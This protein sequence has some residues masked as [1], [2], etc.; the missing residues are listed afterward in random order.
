MYKERD[1]LLTANEKET[2]LILIRNYEQN[3]KY[4]DARKDSPDY[5]AFLIAREELEKFFDTYGFEMRF[6]SRDEIVDYDLNVAFGMFVNDGNINKGEIQISESD[7]NLLEANIMSINRIL[8]D[9]KQ[10]T[11]WTDRE[12]ETVIAEAKDMAQKLQTLLQRLE[13]F[14]STIAGSI[15]Y[16]KRICLVKD[17]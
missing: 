9:Y 15:P 6:P 2:L 10:E 5:K 4:K 12:M 3:A 8:N 14:D 13:V 7:K 1:V 17:E 11:P 16:F